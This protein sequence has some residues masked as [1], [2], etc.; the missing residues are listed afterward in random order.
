M[1]RKGGNP[2]IAK[3]GFQ[4]TYDWGEPCDQRIAFRVPKT[5]K[6]RL[7]ENWAEI[8]RQ[9]IAKEIGWDVS[10]EEE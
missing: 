3:H 1:A 10:N 7:P 8:C 5:M 9:A 6:E 2:D 4:R